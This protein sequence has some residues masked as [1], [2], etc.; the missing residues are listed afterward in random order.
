MTIEQIE[1]VI[2]NYDRDRGIIAEYK[3]LQHLW[4]PDVKT[5]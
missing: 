1:T 3:F 5:G 2:G 4:D